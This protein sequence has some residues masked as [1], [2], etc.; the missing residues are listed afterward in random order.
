MADTIGSPGI[1]AMICSTID[2]AF[3][4]LPVNPMRER[5]PAAGMPISLRGV[6]TQEQK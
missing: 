5:H 2:F 1:T 3:Y 4:S 6:Y